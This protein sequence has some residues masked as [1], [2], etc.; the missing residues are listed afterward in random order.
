V[1]LYL[2]KRIGLV[3]SVLLVLLVFLSVLIHLVPGD[4]AR[5]IMG[6]LASDAFAATVRQEMG[7]DKPIPL[8]VLDFVTRAAHGD[9]GLDFVSRRSVASMIGAVLP[10]TVVLALAGLAIAVLIGLPLGVIAAVHPNSLVDRL[11]ASVSIVLITLPPYVAGLILLLVFSVELSWFPALGAGDF[12]HPI[13]YL[14]RLA[15]P[16]TALAFGWIGYIARLTRASMLEV[17]HMNYI[18]TAHAFGIPQTRIHYGYALRVAVIPVV[19]LLG[20]GLGHLLGGAIFVEVIFSR[21]GL[22]SL[23]YDAIATR[24]FPVIRGSAIVVATIFV[25]TNLI[26]DLCY[27]LL[28]PRIR[29]EATP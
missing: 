13:D 8:Q 19:A 16:A 14:A 26:T 11:I 3:A 27:R 5:I 22:G 29:V 20:T 25:V 1:L 18:R 2:A 17:L 7:L 24:N 23:F 10:H 21:P 4:P 15:L 6:P 28:D 12:D 9:L